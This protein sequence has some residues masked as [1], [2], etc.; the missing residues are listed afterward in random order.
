MTRICN[1]CSPRQPNTVA[2]PNAST[3]SSLKTP[4][5][6]HWLRNF[7]AGRAS[8]LANS[9]T[10]FTQ[11]AGERTTQTNY[12]S[13]SAAVLLT[14]PA[15]AYGHGV[16][17]ALLCSPWHRV[18]ALRS[19]SS[20]RRT[21]KVYLQACPRDV[22]LLLACL[23]AAAAAADV[24]RPLRRRP[25]VPYYPAG[26]ASTHR[27][28]KWAHFLSAMCVKTGPLDL[29]NHAAD[30]PPRILL[31]TPTRPISVSGT[32]VGSVTPLPRSISQSGART[33]KSWCSLTLYY[34]HRA[35]LACHWVDV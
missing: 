27:L 13:Q 31:C 8:G 17:E 5:P 32:P 30:Q 35:V 18:G 1:P 6:F 12:P 25:T 23:L 7:K 3:S 33:A 10:F 16:S 34:I 2:V 21:C 15:F 4:P 22:P 26:S 24:C 11:R 19:V 20:H 14:S 9:L 29:P 28:H